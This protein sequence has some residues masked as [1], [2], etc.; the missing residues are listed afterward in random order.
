VLGFIEITPW[1]WA[2]FILFVVVC[3][4]VDMGAFH[5]RSRTVTFR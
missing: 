3:V 2:G 1:H 4:A 5:R